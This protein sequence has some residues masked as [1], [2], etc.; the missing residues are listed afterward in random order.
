MGYNEDPGK[1]LIIFTEQISHFQQNNK[2]LIHGG[3]EDWGSRKL[4]TNHVN[5]NGPWEAFILIR[6]QEMVK[7]IG[8][9]RNFLPYLII[10]I[11]QFTY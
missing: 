8:K 1:T 6:E 2:H 7:R 10:L 3:D 5:E 4:I 9:Q 11:N